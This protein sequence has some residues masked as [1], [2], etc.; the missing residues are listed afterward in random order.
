MISELVHELFD[1]LQKRVADWVIIS[2]GPEV[3]NDRDERGMRLVEE[4]IELGQAIGL[5]QERLH[6]LV[7]YVYSRPVGHLPQEF[8]GTAVTLLA[9]AETCNINVGEELIKEIERVESIPVE[10][11]RAKNR[12]K[13][14]AGIG[15]YNG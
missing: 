11:F 4:A 1:R 8:G 7:D 5:S 2:F 15:N 9:A 12:V 6:V 3:L 13:K 14:S 10:H